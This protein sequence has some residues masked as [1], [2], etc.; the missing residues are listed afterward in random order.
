MLSVDLRPRLKG[1]HPLVW[2][3]EALE[4]DPGYELRRMFNLRAAYLDGLIYLAVA[5]G[6]EPWNGLVVCTSHDCHAD[7]QRDFP[8]LVAHAVLGKWLYL[9]QNHP[10]FES[11]AQK[12]AR[13]ALERDPRLGVEPKPRRSRAAKKKP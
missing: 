5:Q 3:F 8:E 11:T 10:E 4:N 12:L 7:L 2:V 9:S 13:A 1:A 6:E